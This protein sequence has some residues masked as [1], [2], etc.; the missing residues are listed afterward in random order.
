[1]KVADGDCLF[2]TLTTHYTK[3]EKGVRESWERV[4][5]ELPRFLQRM[6]RKGFTTYVWTKEA[7]EDG[8]CHVHIVIKNH[9]H[10]FLYFL[11]KK[12]LTI[13]RLD[14]EPLREKIKT[15]WPCGHVDI[16]VISTEKAGEYITKEIGKTSHIE[17]AVKRARAGKDTAADRKKLWG[18]YMAK[19]LKLRRWGVSRDLIKHMTN[20]TDDEKEYDLPEYA[21]L[22][23]YITRADWFEPFTQILDR[24]SRAYKE[25]ARFFDEQREI[26]RSVREHLKPDTS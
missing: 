10:K 16:Q 4:R 24:R 9:G 26:G 20:P 11:D 2:I 6:R 19:K 3:N 15:A 22:P 25:I 7:H 17:E 8:G 5:A 21:I 23:K 13:L 1:M 18:H 12:N 14:D